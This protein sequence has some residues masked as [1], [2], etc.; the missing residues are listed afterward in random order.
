MID[1][2]LDR[3]DAETTA[4]L[5][6]S[7]VLGDDARADRLLSLTGLT[8][9][10]LR[11]GLRERGVQL[12]VLDFLANHESDLLAAADALQCEPGRIIAARHALGGRNYE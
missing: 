5:A 10:F 8:P 7:W 3:E 4:L 12:A 9:D 11:E 2:T 6:L 1:P